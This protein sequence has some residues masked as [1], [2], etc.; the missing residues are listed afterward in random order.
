MLPR[1]RTMEV[2]THS[3]NKLWNIVS[4]ARYMQETY[5]KSSIQIRRPKTKWVKIKINIITLMLIW[6][7]ISNIIWISCYSKMSYIQNSL[8]RLRKNR[9]SINSKWLIRLNNN[10]VNYL[11]IWQHFPHQKTIKDV[12]KWILIRQLLK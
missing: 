1:A 4:S 2:K 7:N 10:R 12:I 3:E 11:Q 5:L 8:T 9:L 6:L